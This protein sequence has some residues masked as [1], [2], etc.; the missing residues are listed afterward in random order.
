MS[1]D[2]TKTKGKVLEGV[3]VGDKMDKTVVD[4]LT[5]SSNI[6]STESSTRRVLNTRRM[7]Q[8]TPTRLVTKLPSLRL[9]HYQKTSH[10][11]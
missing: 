9:F 2:T 7:M 11:R 10:S 8:I 4:L 3:V 5:A 6:Q 1:A